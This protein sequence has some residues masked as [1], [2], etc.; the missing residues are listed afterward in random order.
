[1][2][3]DHSHTKINFQSINNFNVRPEIIKLLKK[4]IE[5]TPV[6]IRLRNITLDTPLIKGNKKKMK[7]MRL[8]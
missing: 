8:Y 1:M 4:N 3:L 7:Q 2:K 6:N 5:S